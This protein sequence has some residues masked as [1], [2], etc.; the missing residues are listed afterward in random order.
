MELTILLGLLLL[1]SLAASRWG[2]D[3]RDHAR[4]HHGTGGLLPSAVPARS[5]V[6]T[7]RPARNRGAGR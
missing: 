1:L 7:G 6:V 2:R 5:T 4:D 3:S